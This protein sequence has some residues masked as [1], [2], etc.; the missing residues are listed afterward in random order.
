MFLK[1]Q[2]APFPTIVGRKGRWKLW[3]SYKIPN[4]SK[5]QYDLCLEMYQ[6]GE[7]FPKNTYYIAFGNCFECLYPFML[8]ISLFFGGIAHVNCVTDI[9]HVNHAGIDYKSQCQA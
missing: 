2:K 1:Q 6:H 8:F 9:A 5:Y 3:M 7:I 4:I